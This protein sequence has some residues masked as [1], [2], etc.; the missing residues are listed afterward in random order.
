MPEMNRTADRSEIKA[1][2]SGKRL[3]VIQDPGVAPA[4]GFRDLVFG[5]GSDL[6]KVAQLP[7][8]GGPRLNQCRGAAITRTIDCAY[9]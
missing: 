9:S 2:G 7:V 4:E 8:E 5:H 3:N 1:P 6:G